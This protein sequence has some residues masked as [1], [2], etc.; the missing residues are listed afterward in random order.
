MSYYSERMQV[1]L[2]GRAGDWLH[3]HTWPKTFVLFAT[4]IASLAAYQASV[5]WLLLGV[6][7]MSV[8]FA[9]CFI[10]GYAVYIIVVGFRIRFGQ[11]LD[12]HD[13]M[14]GAT[15]QIET[16]NPMAQDF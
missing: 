1:V 9:L 8:R 2:S 10:V 6:R 4:T 11:T 3:R 7:W 16:H 5:S 13:L 12:A 14:D 15:G